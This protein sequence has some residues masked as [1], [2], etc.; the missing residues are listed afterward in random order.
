MLVSWNI[1]KN[2]AIDRSLSIQYIDLSDS[3]DLIAFDGLFKL[4]CN[5]PKDGSSDQTDFETNF[6]AQGNV[7]HPAQST[8]VASQPPFG[9]KTIVVNGVTKKLYA[10]NTGIQASVTTGANTINYTATYAWAKIIG[11]EAINC[12]ALDKVDFKVHDTAAGTYS[13]YPNAM[14]NQFSYSLNLP[15]DYYIKMAQFDADLYPGMIIKIE[16]TSVS[17]KT[18]GINIIM[19]EVKS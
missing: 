10:R 13:G 4:E 2:F 5:L 16:Y 19:N 12:E 15:K 3:Y 9:S 7:P 8:T 6:K 11:V 14:L 17:N 1:I 18:I